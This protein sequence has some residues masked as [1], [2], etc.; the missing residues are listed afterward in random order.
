M[1]H[2]G[3]QMGRSAC[4][5]Q[6]TNS[7]PPRGGT[8]SNRSRAWD[9]FFVGLIWSPFQSVAPLKAPTTLDGSSDGICTAGGCFA[10]EG[11]GEGR[12]ER[13]TQVGWRIKGQRRERPL[14]P[15][16]VS[17]MG[18]HLARHRGEAGVSHTLCLLL[19]RRA[20]SEAHR[21]DPSPARA[22]ALFPA[23]PCLPLA[24]NFKL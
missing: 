15:K 6:N 10:G 8:G 19:G 1:K 7:A 16:G 23:T 5:S 17:H 22:W 3:R 20:K 12:G 13:G 2:R 11:G 9:L 14:P 4:Q 18:F 24:L 21:G